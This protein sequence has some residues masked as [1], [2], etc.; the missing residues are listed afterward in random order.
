MKKIMMSIIV[1]SAL[2]VFAA[3]ASAQEMVAVAQTAAAL[4]PTQCI[5]CDPS[6]SWPDEHVDFNYALGLWWYSPSHGGCFWAVCSDMHAWCDNGAMAPEDTERQDRINE[7]LNTLDGDERVAALVDEFPE[8]IH[9]TT[10]GEALEVFGAACDEAK[11]VGR[12]HVTMRQAV[13][14]IDA[15]SGYLASR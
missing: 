14:V 12:L 8:Y 2:L 3:P 1:S 4:G 15:R 9:L 5:I 13:A 6:C 7:I 11:M 10:G